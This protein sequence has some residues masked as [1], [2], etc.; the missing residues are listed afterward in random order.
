MRKHP[1]SRKARRTPP[2]RATRTLQISIPQEQQ[3]PTTLEL[4]WKQGESLLDLAKR[5]EDTLGQHIEGSC[6]GTMACSTCHVYIN[7]PQVRE[8]LPAVQDTELD[9]LE[10]AYQ[11]DWESSRLGCQVRLTPPLLELPRLAIALPD[12]VNNVWEEE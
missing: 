6:G 1:L 5:N 3:E 7:D 8:A 12:G 4:T 9:L 11:P 10:L 2:A